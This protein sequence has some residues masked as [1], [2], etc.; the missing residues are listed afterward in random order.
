MTTLS[1]CMHGKATGRTLFIGRG[2]ALRIPNFQ[3]HRGPIIGANPVDYSRNS[4]GSA[5]TEC[6]RLP[7]ASRPPLPLTSQP[8]PQDPTTYSTV[9]DVS[10]WKAI[11][12]RLLDCTSSL[13]T[14]TRARSQLFMVLNIFYNLNCN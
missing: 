2:F 7:P 3:E 10:E 12:L 11:N 1:P 8:W 9:V 4:A 14:H 6:T 13:L 5:Q